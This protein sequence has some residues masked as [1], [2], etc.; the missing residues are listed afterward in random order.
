MRQMA[1]LGVKYVI[2]VVLPWIALDMASNLSTL[3]SRIQ[4]T[5]GINVTWCLICRMFNSYVLNSSY[6]GPVSQKLI[7]ITY[8]IGK[9]L[10]TTFDISIKVMYKIRIL[11][12]SA[13]NKIK[14]K[15][16]ERFAAISLYYCKLYSCYKHKV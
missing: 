4:V 13:S 15:L 10:W 1:D 14:V 11:L 8:Q 3:V 2:L 6:G 9:L 16:H 12:R 5:Q 7:K